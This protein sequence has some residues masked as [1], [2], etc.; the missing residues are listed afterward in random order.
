MPSFAYTFA[1]S[2]GTNEVA[3]CNRALFRVGHTKPITALDGTSE[4]A[5]VCNAIYAICREELLAALDWPFARRHKVLVEDVTVEHQAWEHAYALPA[6]C[7]VPREIWMGL[8]R[9]RTDDRT[10]FG[11]EAKA[12]LS[13]QL[14]WCDVAPVVDEAP[15]L[16]YTANVTTVA[17]WPVLFSDALAWKLAIELSM[18]L[19]VKREL[20]QD[21]AQGYEIS[22]SRAMTSAAE[23]EQA[24]P[25][26]DSEF[27][28]ARG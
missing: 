27:L 1:T 14:L 4:E 8:R 24:D 13:G 19:A 28:A 26:P 21:A 20:R 23:Q 25:S 12:D 10:P 3:V 22:L 15:Y 2:I 11:L 5:R 9:P 18:A 6:D 7:L 16:R 17:A